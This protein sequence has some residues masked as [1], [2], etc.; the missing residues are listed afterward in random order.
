[1][2]QNAKVLLGV[3]ALTALLGAGRLAVDRWLHPPPAA[4]SESARGV[5]YTLASGELLQVPGAARVPS[6]DDGGR[7]FAAATRLSPSAP[8]GRPVC[9]LKDGAA[10]TVLDYANDRGVESF[11]VRTPECEGWIAGVTPSET[12]PSCP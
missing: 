10:V 4:K 11:L 2:S 5:C 12:Y 1:V 3:A 6:N 9:S 7:W 8:A